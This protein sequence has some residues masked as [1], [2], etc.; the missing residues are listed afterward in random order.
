MNPPLSLPPGSCDTHVHFYDRRFPTAEVAHL[1]PPDASP[2]AYRPL[3]SELGIDRVV[4]VQPTTYGLD[5]RCQLA[6]MAELGEMARGVMVID[7]AVSG[8]DL[9]ALTEAGVRGARFHMLPGGSIGWEEL[10]PVAKLI[11]PFGWHIQLQ[12]NGR[13]LHERREQ[14]RGLP[15]EIVVDHI[16]RFMPPVDVDHPGFQFVLDLLE[17]GRGWAKLSAPYESSVSGPPGYPDVLPLIDA[18]LERVPEQLLWASN[19]PHPG[20]AQP[21]QPP[22]L[23][24]L[25]E[26]YLPDEGTRQQVLV[27]NPARLYDY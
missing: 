23:M 9:S 17:S 19:W 12:L 14:L 1:R 6:A 25:L 3:Q 4:V 20:Q 24:A 2:S 18:L 22:D 7:S 10:E 15:V 11:A 5:N 16:G 21:P 13:E 27:D 26:R 8:D